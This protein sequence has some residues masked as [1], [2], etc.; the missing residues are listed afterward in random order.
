M[1][2]FICNVFVSLRDWIVY[3]KLTKRTSV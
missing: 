3:G 2:V 1:E